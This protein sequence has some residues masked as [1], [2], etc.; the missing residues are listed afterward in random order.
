M[1]VSGLQG[2]LRVLCVL[3]LDPAATWLVLTTAFH[4]ELSGISN[5][6]ILTKPWKVTGE[7]CRCHQLD[8]LGSGLSDGGSC[9]I[10]FSLSE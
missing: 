9:M 8:P 2:L 7:E 6:V 5:W 3:R 4:L 1:G 10:L